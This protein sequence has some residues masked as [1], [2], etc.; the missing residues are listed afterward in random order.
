MSEQKTSKAERLSRVNQYLAEHPEG[1][2][3]AELADLCGVHKRTAQRDLHDLRALGV[4]LCEDTPRSPRYRL[5]EGYYLPPLELSLEEALALGL[6]AKSREPDSEALPAFVT[7]LARLADALPPSAARLVQPDGSQE[8]R[9]S[10]GAQPLVLGTIAL[11]LIGDR[12]LQIRHRP[13]SSGT[14]QTVQVQQVELAWSEESRMPELIGVVLD[15]D[16]SVRLSVGTI[17]EAVLLP[18]DDG[19]PSETG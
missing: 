9:S 2:T 5:V 17:T 7:A 8:A 13:D 1:L 19:A 4:T 16:A 6:A 15:T 3:V 10:D 18:V 11:A 14:D 12:P